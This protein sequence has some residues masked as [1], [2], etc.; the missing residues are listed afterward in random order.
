MK[1]SN[2][3]ISVENL[4]KRYRIG[5]KAQR[6]DTLS[7]AVAALFNKPKANLQRLR[8]LTEFIEDGRQQDDVIWA[9]NDVS[10]EVE[11]GEVLG[12]IG[13]NGSGK[14][15]LLKV[16]CGIT[17]PTKGQVVVQG[18]VGS[19]M[20][21]GTGFHPELTG[22]DNIFLNGAILGMTRREINHKFDE[23]VAFSE[24]ERFL[25]T[26]L[27]RYSNG[28]RTRLGFSVA[29]H[30][31]PE[32]LILDEVLMVGDIP[33]RIKALEK[34]KELASK[35]ITVLLAAN[36]MMP[37]E[38]L[39]SRVVLLENGAIKQVGNTEDVVAT[40]LS[41]IEEGTSQA[42]L[43]RGAEGNVEAMPRSNR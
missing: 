2:A 10:F 7:A 29:A 25:D 13:R 15:T 20:E 41:S 17:S 24:V 21:A 19:L 26:P 31:E 23:I 16:I 30:L 40:Y 12:I 42:S 34:I 35:D 37:V 39:C 5:L 11:H 4:S 3:V 1:M 6:H 33:F 18:R 38:A 43:E 9:L 14:S 22:R 32:I 8:G 27:K 28:M 36:L